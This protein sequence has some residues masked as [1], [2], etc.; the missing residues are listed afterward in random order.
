MRTAEAIVLPKLDELTFTESDHVYRLNGS[1]IPSVTSIMEPL[2]RKEYG[3][4]DERTLRRAAN[5][6]TSVHFAIENYLKFGIVDCEP[7]FQGYMAGFLEWYDQ[8]R[9]IIIG[10]EIR[11]YHK[12]F[13]YGGTIDL[14]AI[15][16]GKL[17]LIDFKT[18]SR[19][20]EKNCRVQLEAYSQAL[21]SHGIKVDAKYI[22]HL[23]PTGKWQYQMFVEKD[24]E[25]W[26]VFGSL[27][28]VYDYTRS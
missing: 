10:S 5:R 3:S 24:A 1:A 16:D 11:T 26:R 4:I 7:D 13:R 17:V 19:L 27:K 15:I 8:Y 20:I 14:L 18:T 12:L 9:P 22:L 23:T 21:A 28:T 6:G 2:S 25:A